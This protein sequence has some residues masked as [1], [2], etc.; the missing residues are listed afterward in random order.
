MAG[1]VVQIVDL[2]EFKEFI[3]DSL[4]VIDFYATWCGPCKVISPKFVAFATEFPAVKFGKVDVD[5]ASDVSEECSISAMPTFQFY[6]NGVKVEEVKGASES[7]L[8]EALESL[9]K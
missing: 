8:R 4:A 6:K 5:E 1:S 9:S 7:K 3:K 2:A